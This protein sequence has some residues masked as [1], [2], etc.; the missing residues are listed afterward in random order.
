LIRQCHAEA[1][2]STSQAFTRS[3]KI[4]HPLHMAVLQPLQSEMTHP[5]CGTTSCAGFVQLL[6]R[7]ENLTSLD[8]PICLHL[9]ATGFRG[10]LLVLWESCR[11]VHSNVS[12]RLCFIDLVLG[13]RFLLLNYCQ[14]SWEI[15]GKG[16]VASDDVTFLTE[17]SHLVW[18]AGSTIPTVLVRCPAL[19]FAHS[20][21]AATAV[22]CSSSA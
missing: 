4:V 14:L 21:H 15:I 9:H 12:S 18:T 5:H 7:F 1:T 20:D 17:Q 22:S 11:E 16:I 10:K 2:S 13:D 19:L 3:L 6:V 8:F